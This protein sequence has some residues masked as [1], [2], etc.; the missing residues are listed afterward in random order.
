MTDMIND[1]QLQLVYHIIGTWQDMQRLQLGHLLT[2]NPLPSVGLKRSADFFFL[3]FLGQFNIFRD[4]GLK[5][6]NPGLSRRCGL[7]KNK[8]L[9]K[10]ALENASSVTDHVVS[11]LEL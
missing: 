7:L 5:Y 2:R 10:R 4:N 8:T 3:K 11:L 6:Q 1:D 9:I